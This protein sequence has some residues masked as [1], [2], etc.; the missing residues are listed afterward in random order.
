MSKLLTMPSFEQPADRHPN[1]T[2]ASA[3]DRDYQLILAWIKEGAK[4][5]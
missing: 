3:T 1:V 4:D 2:F 5:N